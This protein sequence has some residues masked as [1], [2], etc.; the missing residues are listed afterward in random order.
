MGEYTNKLMSV[1]GLSLSLAKAEF[2]LR[3]EGSYLGILW[4]LLNP[5]F[6]FLL[7]FFVFSD[8]LGNN[9]PNYPIYLF[10]GIIMF[11]FFQNT[12]SESTKIIRGNFGIIKSINFSKESLICS[13]ALKNLFSH[14][15]EVILFVVLLLMFKVSLVGVI[16]YLIVLVFFFFFIIGASFILGSL[17]IYFMDLENIWVFA[18][19]LIWLATPIFYAI[20]GQSKLFYFN[21]FNPLYYFMTISRE[22]IISSK[23]PELWIIF[24]ALIYVLLFLII[25]LFLFNKLKN[26]FAELI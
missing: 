10:L 3:N 1:A 25:G 17:S 14:L 9:I 22:L 19:R 5:I 23:I 2:K 18:S 4:Y 6:M 16:Y 13:V 24:G 7:L 12:T 15:F 11:N 26:K 21:L 20:E 8:R